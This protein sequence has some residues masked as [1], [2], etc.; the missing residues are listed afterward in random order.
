MSGL[1]WVRSVSL[2]GLL[3]AVAA[4]CSNPKDDE[5]FVPSET[6]AEQ[7]KAGGAQLAEAV[8][9]DSLKAADS[10]ARK[11]LSCPANKAVCPASIRPAGVGDDCF[12]YSKASVDACVE[13]IGKYEACEDFESHPCLVTAVPKQCAGSVE[14][15]PGEGGAGGAPSVPGDAGAGGELSAAGAAGA[16]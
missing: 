7:P 5:D 6:G 8:A 2:A 4:S 15:A 9:C 16:P 10:A 1:R 11:A 3:L 12:S 14:P 13:A